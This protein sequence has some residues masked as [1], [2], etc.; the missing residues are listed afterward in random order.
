MD[1]NLEEQHI[2]NIFDKVGLEEINGDVSSDIIKPRNVDPEDSGFSDM[3]KQDLLNL[4][5]T[6][7]KG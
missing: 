7:K 3:D 4:T 5:V 6:Q 2:M 1:Y